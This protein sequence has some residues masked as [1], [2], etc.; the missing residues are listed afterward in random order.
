ME[1]KYNKKRAD[2]C[3]NKRG[4]DAKNHTQKTVK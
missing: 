4:L 3:A 1:N 2:N